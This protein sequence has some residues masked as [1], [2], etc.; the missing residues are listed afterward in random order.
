MPKV[1]FNLEP[2]ELVTGLIRS[3]SFN[4]IFS[5]ITLNRKK[6]SHIQTELFNYLKLN[7]GITLAPILMI[8]LEKSLRIEPKIHV[9]A[10]DDDGLVEYK[11][12]SLMKKDYNGHFT[13]AANQIIFDGKVSKKVKQKSKMYGNAHVLFYNKTEDNDRDEEV[14][15]I[16][17]GPSSKLDFRIAARML[18]DN[19]NPGSGFYHTN[20][21]NGAIKEVIKLLLFVLIK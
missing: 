2:L 21:Q 7:D 3:T 11:L 17:L 16:G 5:C 18:H 10:N 6:G 4:N 1:E 9:K 19:N 20:L 12:V 13:A 15:S 8:K 14:H